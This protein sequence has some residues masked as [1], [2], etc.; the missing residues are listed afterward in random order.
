VKKGRLEFL[1]LSILVGC[2][3]IFAAI[4]MVKPAEDVSTE[5]KIVLGTIGV[6]L[7]GF[8]IGYLKRKAEEAWE[9]ALGARDRTQ[10]IV[11]ALP[12]G[13]VLADDRGTVFAANARAA[14]LLG[15]DELEL[16]EA[17]LAG[18]LPDEGAERAALGRWGAFEL[19]M[20]SGVL[21]ATLAPLTLSKGQGSILILEPPPSGGAPAGATAADSGEARAQRL[22]NI[23]PIATRAAGDI[24]RLAAQLEEKGIAGSIAAN[25]VRLVQAVH[26]ARLAD[27]LELIERGNYAG[28]LAPETVNLGKLAAAALHA[29]EPFFTI[30]QVEL[31]EDL[32]DA[33]P[34][35]D[36]DPDRI[37]L[38]LTDLFDNAL[39]MTPTGGK[40]RFA[41]EAEGGIVR[42]TITDNGCG[43]MREELERVFDRDH[44]R[45][46][47]AERTGTCLGLGL[48]VA[49]E[50]AEAHG[51]QLWGESAPGKGS[52]F[53]VELPAKE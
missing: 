9:S 20:A 6:A 16:T 27:E 45:K 34:E 48:F 43:M 41:A 53:T 52:R 32:P 47:A 22:S 28:A 2:V 14:G 25:A 13:L 50:I 33:L 37:G 35:A 19:K 31:E 36:A 51:G 15:R 10:A 5:E 26:A 4:Q 7:A 17:E 8:Y 39:A 46:C 23:F 29:I 12:L 18:V 24:A 3:V 49:K 21:R 11:E 40:V 44:R 30:G 1:L 38:L 42:F